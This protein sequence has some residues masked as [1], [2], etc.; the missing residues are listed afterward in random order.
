MW[1][2]GIIMSGSSLEDRL[3][4]LEAEVAE[5]KHRL[6]DQ[7]PKKSGWKAIEGTFLNDPYYEEAMKLGREG[8]E[9]LRP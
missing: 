1:K 5:L 7:E 6:N 9:S 8:R 2:G 3:A 4:T